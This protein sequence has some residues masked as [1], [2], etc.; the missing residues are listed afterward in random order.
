M[1][2]DEVGVR[3]PALKK[4]SPCLIAGPRYY[5]RARKV[6]FK[7]FLQGIAFGIITL[8]GAFI[9][10]E[11]LREFIVNSIIP[12]DTTEP[13]VKN[14]LKEFVSQ[15]LGSVGVILV[16]LG[17]VCALVCLFGWIASCCPCGLLLKIYAVLL[18]VILVM[19]ISFTGY[20]FGSP[21]YLPN[22][23]L[24][25]MENALQS[26]SKDSKDE[27]GRVIWSLV[28]TSNNEICCGVN[29]YKDFTNLKTAELPESCCKT[30]AQGSKS[31]CDVATAE[32]DKVPGCTDKIKTFVETAET[33]ILPIPI[34]LIFGL[35]VLLVVVIIAAFC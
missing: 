22:R 24:G 29:G 33:K 34:A 5:P 31:S 8:F 26:Y 10:S 12:D 14:A 28:M 1:S 21:D 9:K 32:A 25:L 11:K 13:A 15:P 3:H 6:E 7:V 19:Q 2:V 23:V 18:G 35:L 20:V 27:T 4:F 17:V 16:S 30:K